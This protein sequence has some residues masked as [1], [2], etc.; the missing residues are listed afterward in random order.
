MSY[1]T[2]LFL[3]YVLG[4]GS[5]PWTNSSHCSATQL[6]CGFLVA[7]RESVCRDGAE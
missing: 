6:F 7:P 2:L 1:M 3:Y 5:F 4:T